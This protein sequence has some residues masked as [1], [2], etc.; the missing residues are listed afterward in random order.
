MIV[1]VSSYVPDSKSLVP[2]D[3]WMSYCFATVGDT[4]PPAVKFT[5]PPSGLSPASE[6]TD[7]PEPNVP[8]K[9]ESV[10]EL[11]IQFFG[12]KLQFLLLECLVLSNLILLM[13]KR[14]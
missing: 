8:D 3:T 13:R 1:N 7:K 5:A 14:F 2:V 9:P 11:S 10:R 4:S 12:E 6:L